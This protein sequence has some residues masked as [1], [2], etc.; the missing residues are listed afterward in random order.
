M[1]NDLSATPYED[2]FLGTG[3]SRLKGVQSCRMS[4]VRPNG[5]YRTVA[6][7]DLIPS[8][9]SAL[10]VVNSTSQRGMIVMLCCAGRLSLL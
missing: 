8:A 3:G 7:D 5:Q 1:V 4:H 9:G 10:S 6:Q 2:L